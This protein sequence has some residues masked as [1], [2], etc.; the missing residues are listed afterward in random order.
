M[1]ETEGAEPL[2]LTEISTDDLERIAAAVAH[3]RLKTP[4]SVV[5]LAQAGLGHVTDALAPYFV[6]DASALGAVIHAVLAERS[7]AVHA[8]L[9]LVWSGTDR[10]PSLAR[11]TRIVVSDLFARAARF[12]TLAGYSFDHGERIFEPLHR[13]MCD[14]KVAARFFVDI[15]QLHERLK[16]ALRSSQRTAR[17]L[18]LDRARNEGTAAYADA[19]LALF[20][21][22]YWPFE[23]PRPELYYDPSTL[24]EQTFTSLH[25]KCI[26]VD[27]E[28]TLIT[29]ANFT[30]RG[31]SRNIEVGVLV[32]DALFAQALEQQWFNLVNTEAVV[33]WGR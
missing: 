21:E 28:Q 15:R 8:R 10:G 17:L 25:A 30:E 33:R 2:G 32:R 26:V 22:L 5:R 16:Q 24:S 3:G 23:G 31:Q 1:S 18:P 4:L 9:S 20:I 6:L 27:H 11:Y 12:V 7:R 29:S 19:V 13:S 14:R